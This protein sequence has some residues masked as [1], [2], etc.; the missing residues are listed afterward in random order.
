MINQHNDKKNLRNDQVYHVGRK[1]GY[2]L[3]LR[4]CRNEQVEYQRIYNN[5]YCRDNKRLGTFDIFRSVSSYLIKKMNFNNLLIHFV[6]F[7][8]DFNSSVPFRELYY[9]DET[10]KQIAHDKCYVFKHS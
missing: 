1:K 2:V 3:A 9:H 4:Q 5:H 10:H 7:V 6:F 8:N